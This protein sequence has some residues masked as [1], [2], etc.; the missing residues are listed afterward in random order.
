MLQKFPKIIFILIV[1]AI[2]GALSAHFVAL[3]PTTGNQ[4]WWYD[5]SPG[6]FFGIATALVFLWLYRLSPIKTLAWVLAA[7]AS[8][9][10]AFRIGDLIPNPGN[11]LF[12]ITFYA[13]TG[14]LE[15]SLLGIFFWLIVRRT[16]FVHVAVVMSVG[17]VAN[18]LIAIIFIT[19]N[20]ETFLTTTR[21]ALAFISWHMSL[22]FALIGPALMQKPA[23]RAHR[24]HEAN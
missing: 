13:V 3:A 21:L 24:A 7:I 10:A 19:N 18:V 4:G 1:T 9:Y 23:T 15:A 5:Y 6:I 14:L 20:V 17:L 12:F 16:S 8:N 22:T 2:S 11:W